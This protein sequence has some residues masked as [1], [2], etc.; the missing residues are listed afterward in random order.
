M[1]RQDKEVSTKDLPYSLYFSKMDFNTISKGP[2][3]F[4]LKELIHRKTK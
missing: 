4:A 3:A 2:L 1:I